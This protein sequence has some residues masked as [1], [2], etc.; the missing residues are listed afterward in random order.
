MTNNTEKPTHDLTT[1]HLLEFKHPGAAILALDEE[2]N[3]PHNIDLKWNAQKQPTFELCLGQIGA[4]LGI[5]F[6]GTYDADYVAAILVK[7]MRQRSQLIMLTPPIK[8]N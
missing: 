6:D 3:K 7:H 2:L 5:V 1:H 8:L 4:D